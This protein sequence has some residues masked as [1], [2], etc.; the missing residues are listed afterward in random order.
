MQL[1][2]RCETL[3]SEKSPM[4]KFQS[5]GLDQSLGTATECADGSL[6]DLCLRA[7]P[8]ALNSTDYLCRHNTTP[9]ISYEPPLPSATVRRLNGQALLE[10]NLLLRE[11]HRGRLSVTRGCRVLTKS[12]SQAA[13]KLPNQSPPQACV[14]TAKKARDCWF[15]PKSQC[16]RLTKTYAS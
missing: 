4:Q 8:L 3:L 14:N 1:V 6:S 16:A 13:G 9:R 2:W 12:V 11:W 5:N 15:Q 10:Q 7:H